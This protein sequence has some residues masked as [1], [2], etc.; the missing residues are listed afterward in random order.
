MRTSR[1]LVFSCLVFW[2]TFGFF[3]LIAWLIVPRHSVFWDNPLMMQYPVD[4]FDQG[5]TAEQLNQ[6]DD[7][8]RLVRYV[9]D[10]QRWYRLDP[11]PAIPAEGQ[12][13][14][15][16]GDS[17]TW[18]WGLVDRNDAYPG[19]IQDLLPANVDS[20]N[21]GVPGYSSL[22]GRRYVEDLLPQ[23]HDRLVAITLYFG[24]NDATENGAPDA[25]KLR[26]ES[27]R[28]A[29]SLRHLPLY[30]GLREILPSKD[31]DNS[32]PR[33]SPDEY[34]ANIRAMIAMARSYNISVVV[35]VPPVH[36]SWQPGYLRH[37][38]SLEPHVRSDW[39]RSELGKARSLYQQGV[40]FLAQQDD[41]CED[42]FRRAVEHDW[43]VPRIKQD[44]LKR[45]RRLSDEPGVTLVEAPQPFIGAEH[46]WR[47]VDYCHPSAAAHRDIAQH[48]ASALKQRH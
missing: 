9:P 17:S 19:A 44:W 42:K 26:V 14:L 12:L 34:E 47:F 8:S 25:E 29:A 7:P 31:N 37:T 11:E 18:G 13:I 43:V 38:V 16:F 22:Q 30:R 24:N 28:L 36:L 33:V 20:I 4:T 1:K 46:P 39:A 5:V 27:N 3:N 15:H 21:L 10:G 35:I 40:D 2:V 41:R 48:I 45:L 6:S 23:Y 32:Q